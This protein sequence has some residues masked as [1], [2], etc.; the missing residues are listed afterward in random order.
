VSFSPSDLA[1]LRRRIQDARDRGERGATR[2][3]QIHRIIREARAIRHD[4]PSEANG[5]LLI[6]QLMERGVIDLAEAAKMVREKAEGL[7]ELAEHAGERP[8]L[9]EPNG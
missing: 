6:A 8:P 5:F 4:A 2:S 9:Y 7:I 3:G 1:Y